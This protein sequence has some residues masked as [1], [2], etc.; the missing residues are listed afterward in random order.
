M[1]ISVNFVANFTGFVK[2]AFVKIKH[3]TNSVKLYPQK[4]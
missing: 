1:T 3:K 2:I 4:N